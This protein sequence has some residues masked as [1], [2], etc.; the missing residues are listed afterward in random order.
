MRL[1]IVNRRPGMIR[2]GRSHAA[3]ATYTGQEASAAFTQEQLAD[4]A[5]EPEMIMVA[6]EIVTAER[7]EEIFAL[8]RLSQRESAAVAAREAAA[9]E[10]A[11]DR[12][13]AG[14]QGAADAAADAAA[15][16]KAKK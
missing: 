16:K 15:K 2:G 7:V 13:E 10:A 1:I 14:E 9:E 3:V 11:A 4:I 8:A 6:G 12:G 5:G